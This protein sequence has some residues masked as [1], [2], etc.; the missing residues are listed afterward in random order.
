MRHQFEII[1][2]FFYC[3]VIVRLCGDNVYLRNAHVYI[4]NRKNEFLWIKQFQVPSAVSKCAPPPTA[5][6]SGSIQYMLTSFLLD[7][8]EEFNL[9]QFHMG[10]DRVVLILLLA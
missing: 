7:K 6:T 9:H 1:F 3:L 5:D 8:V 2:V 10:K 4:K